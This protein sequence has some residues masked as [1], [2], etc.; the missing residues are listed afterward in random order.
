MIPLINNLTTVL[1]DLGIAFCDYVWSMFIQSGVLIALLLFV[2][3]LIRKRVRASLRYWIWMLVFVKLILPPSLSLPTGIGYW[4]G[5]ILSAVPPVLE[6][7]LTNTRHEFTE[8]P[9]VIS[10]TPIL[11][12]IPQN[13]LPQTT[14]ESTGPATTVV[15]QLNTFTWQAIVFVIWLVGV[16]IFCALLIQRVLFVRRLIV[17]SEP[18]ESQFSERLNQCRRNIG[19]C[20]PVEIRL[21]KS[22]SSPAVCGFF[23][24]V[25]LF[26]AAL[27]RNL[28]PDKLKAVL[29]HE[30]AHIKRRDLWVNFIQTILQ[31][32]YFYNP[33]VWLVN[34]V[35]RRIREKAVD[36]M[37]LVTLGSGIKEYSNTL[38]DIA[39]MAV[40]KTNL[41]LRL[42]GVVESKKA[43]NRRIK[44]MFN[45]PIPQ[46]TKLGIRGLVMILIVGAILL[47]MARAQKQAIEN[48]AVDSEAQSK[49]QLETYFFKR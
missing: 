13:Q 1:N 29:L 36:E 27:I 30:L 24:P 20:R 37:V 32:I 44:H 16:L 26:P 8:P 14:A 5:D 47:P 46:N 41:S 40:L 35:V 38:I 33:L 7:K 18:A 39:E 49:N 22:I 43:L 3:F 28:S 48:T 2:D 21:S 23:K 45:R 31:I 19:V 34:I 9:L 15:S 11:L 17:H 25:I 42:I 6:E 4:R 10:G 12:E